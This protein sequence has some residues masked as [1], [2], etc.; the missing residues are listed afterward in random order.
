MW[1]IVGIS[2]GSEVNPHDYEKE[3]YCAECHTNKGPELIDDH[4]GVC[5][6][7]HPNNIRDHIIDIIP[8]ITLPPSI[9]LT[10]D[11]RM[12]CHTCHEHHNKLKRK[13]M[14]RFDYDTFCIS[15]HRGY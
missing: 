3:E 14:L 8:K 5:I 9:P 15:C 12:A 11:R 13:Q 6:G 7:C 1:S 4:I 10:K 2:S